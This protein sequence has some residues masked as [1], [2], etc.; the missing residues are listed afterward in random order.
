MRGIEIDDVADDLDF[1]GPRPGQVLPG[2]ADGRFKLGN[3]LSV[4]SN[5]YRLVG[6]GDFVY[7]GEAPGFEFSGSDSP[8]LH[9]LIIVENGQMYRL[10][11][12]CRCADYKEVETA[13]APERRKKAR[14][15]KEPTH[16]AQL[17]LERRDGTWQKLSAQIQDDGE[18][19][20]G[21][22]LGEMVRAGLAVLIEGG[23]VCGPDGG[24]ARGF[25]A[26]CTAVSPGLFRAGIAMEDRRK[27]DA[28]KADDFEDY[29]ETLEVNPTA[30]FDTIHK[31]Y[32]VLA[33][34]IHPDNPDSGSE[35]GFKRLVRGYRVLSDPERR[36]AFDVERSRRL[37]KRW[38]IFD[39]DTA[40]PG[41]EQEQRKRRSI[42]ALLY[43]KRIRQPENCGV[44]VPELEQ[45]LAVPRE[46]LEFSLW[47][48]KEQGWIHRSDGGKHQITAKGVE[49]AESTGA[50]QPPTV[51]NSGL[52]SAGLAG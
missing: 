40:V 13:K 35:E 29:Y 11:F 21:V 49:H 26:W 1:A 24:K 15:K 9:L 28:A 16:A 4:S 6:L 23:G 20:V 33:Q 45:L 17:W 2:L 51:R 10:K 12:R 30:S 32:R 46:H 5:N 8:R 39:P 25:V 31:I 37:S 36:A 44:T 42:L 47:F 50:W 41:L 34:R 48:L 22:L 38:R 18:Y 43:N 14:E 19:G 27:E 7:K 3:R 52:L